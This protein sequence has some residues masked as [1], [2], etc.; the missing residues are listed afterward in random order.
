MG[1]NRNVP[2]ISFFFRLRFFD[3]KSGPCTKKLSLQVEFERLHFNCLMKVLKQPPTHMDATTR[4]SWRC[5]EVEVSGYDEGCRRS[6][7]RNME[8]ICWK[9]W[10]WRYQMVMFGELT[11]R[12]QGMRFGLKMVGGNL[13]SITVWSMATYW[14]SNMNGFQYLVWLYSIQVQR[15]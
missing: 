5:C 9:E 15:R 6:L 4:K 2:A 8:R 3:L 11:Y 13:Q 7:Q 10:Y 1:W 14:C 12:S